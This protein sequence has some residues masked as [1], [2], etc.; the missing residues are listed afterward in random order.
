M[1]VNFISCFIAYITGVYLFRFDNSFSFFV[2]ISLF[3]GMTIE[4]YA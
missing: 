1:L 4:R 3:F 2:C